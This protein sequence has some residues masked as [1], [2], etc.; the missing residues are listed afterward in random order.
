MAGKRQHYIP[1]F[2]QTGF[3]SKVDDDVNFTIVYRK[4]GS[5]KEVSTRHVGVEKHFY[6]KPDNTFLD[7][8]ITQAESS[9][10]TNTIVSLRNGCDI[11]QDRK[12]KIAKL[13]S[14]FQ[15]RSRN[16]RLCILEVTNPIVDMLVDEFN[17]PELQIEFIKHLARTQPGVNPLVL[18]LLNDPSMAEMVA[19]SISEVFNDRA[20]FEKTMKDRMA[21]AHQEQMKKSI[22]PKEHVEFLKKL[23]YR[24]VNVEGF[25]LGD[26]MV[27]FC[28]SN[29]GKRYW[30]TIPSKPDEFN[31]V[32]LPISEN[33]L[34]LGSTGEI[35]S[36][37]NEIRKGIIECSYEF[38]IAASRDLVLETSM[39]SI[40]SNSN[41][42]SKEELEYEMQKIRK[43]FGIL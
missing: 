39:N 25:P 9:E 23:N 17:D 26:S 31:Y 20:F 36:E 10:Y 34:L 40:G 24:V 12:E 22:E 1:Q 29:N 27:I 37:Y 16:L 35:P 6:N 14:H 8:L 43:S 41:L 13:I 32:A 33:R 5:P 30:K 2:L 21:I 38:F 11:D 15:I 19:P 7:D 42:I 4:G 28:V 18:E 3:L